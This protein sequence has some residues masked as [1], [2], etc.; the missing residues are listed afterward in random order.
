MRVFGGCAA[1]RRVKVQM[2]DAQGN[3]VG[4]ATL[5]PAA[6]GVTIRLNLMNLTAGRT[7]AFT[8]M[9]SQS[10]KALR[11]LPPGPHFNPDMKHHGL[12]NPDGPHAGD[13]P[14]FT[15]AADG[16]RRRP[17]SRRESRWAMTPIRYSAM[18]APRW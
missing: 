5:S 7:C 13:M 1:K 10:A 11:S 9:P 14:N 6:K 4:T 2:N 16:T 15:V 12:Q 18:A 17:S 8:C 3:S